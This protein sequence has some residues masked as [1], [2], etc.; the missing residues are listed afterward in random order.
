MN[1]LLAPFIWI[2]ALIQCRVDASAFFL[3]RRGIPKS[4]IV[5]G[6][7]SLMVLSLIG[8]T[9]EYLRLGRG[10]MAAI[11]ILLSLF[12]LIGIHRRIKEDAMDE[13]KGVRLSRSDVRDARGPMKQ[14]WF[15]FLFMDLFPVLVSSKEI[16]NLLIFD[17]GWEIT[18]IL[19]FYLAKTPNT[20]PA[21]K[22]TVL[23]HASESA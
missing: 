15:L 23:V 17:I 22:K 8:M 21:Q 18:F 19:I 9:A 3:M 4:R 1:H 2:D 20:P 12:F 14:I 11:F 7:G 10:G 13:E 6:V 5:Y 16:T